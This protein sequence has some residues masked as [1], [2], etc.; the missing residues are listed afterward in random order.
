LDGGTI[1]TLG[2]DLEGLLLVGSHLRLLAL[3]LVNSLVSSSVFFILSYI[4][5]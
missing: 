5:G 4:V 2:E 1:V 3:A